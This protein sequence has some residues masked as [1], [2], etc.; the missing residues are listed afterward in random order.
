MQ[1][2]IMV[3]SLVI[4]AYTSQKK[5]LIHALGLNKDRDDI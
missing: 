5:I 4:F 1:T 2:C 3:Q